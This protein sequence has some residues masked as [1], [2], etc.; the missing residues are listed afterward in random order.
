MEYELLSVFAGFVTV[1]WGMGMYMLSQ[2]IRQAVSEIE[3][4]PRT[5]HELTLSEEIRQ[6]IYDLLVMGID[7]SIGALK[8][9]T[10]F[11]HAVGAFSAFMQKKLS[12]QI[13]PNLFEGATELMADYGNPS[14]EENHPQE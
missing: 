2:Q 5:E 8:P 4:I 7:D 10:A 6:Q 12:Q 14:E 11:D 9:P 13:P 3:N 1:L